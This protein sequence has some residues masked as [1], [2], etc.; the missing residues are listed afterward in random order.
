[1]QKN[2]YT[3][4]G[5]PH[6]KNSKAIERVTSVLRALNLRSMSWSSQTADVRGITVN[7]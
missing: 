3:L 5:L 4:I 2:D 6:L 7:F 1:M